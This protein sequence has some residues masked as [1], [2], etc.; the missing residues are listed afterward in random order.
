MLRRLLKIAMAASF[1]RAWAQKSG[2]WLSV[3]L[4]IVL[5]RFVDRR[6]ARAQ[7]RST[8]QRT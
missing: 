1:G 4:A 7:R 8:Q 3:A 5:F 6:A 2:K